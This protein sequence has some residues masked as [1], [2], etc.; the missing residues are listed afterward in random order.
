MGKDELAAL[1]ARE[2]EAM[3]E[4]RSCPFCGEEAFCGH[5]AQGWAVLC[6]S[7]QCDVSPTTT[8]HDSE[9]QAIAAWNTRTDSALAKRMR[10]LEEALRELLAATP[11]E[12][13]EA[14][15]DVSNCPWMQAK[16]LLAQPAQS[17]DTDKQADASEEGRDAR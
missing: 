10:V 8:Y 15:C 7:M 4:L 16:A 12:E 13:C 3:E 9:E 6:P 17:G 2:G 5:D 1:T 14:D 11:Q